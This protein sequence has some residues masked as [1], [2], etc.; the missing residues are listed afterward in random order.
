MSSNLS[1][2]VTR[3]L[4]VEDRKKNDGPD[5][6]FGEGD[7]PIRQV[8]CLLQDRQYPIPA[9]IEHERQDPDQIRLKG[10]RR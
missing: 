1:S 7:T 5:V 10:T 2:A 6:P 4:H 3:G 8:M 9:F